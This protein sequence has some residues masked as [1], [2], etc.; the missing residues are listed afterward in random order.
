M[1]FTIVAV[2]AC[3]WI[4]VVKLIPN[5]MQA[6]HVVLVIAVVA[7]SMG[8]TSSLF[9]S[10]LVLLSSISIISTSCFM[11][12]LEVAMLIFPAILPAA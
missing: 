10:P 6:S 12:D 2:Q 9:V 7:L 1:C 3:C 8:L 4:A 11:L 5:A